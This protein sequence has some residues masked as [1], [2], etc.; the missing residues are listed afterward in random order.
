MCGD[1][2]AAGTAGTGGS[3][4]RSACC[5]S[6]FTRVRDGGHALL[7]LFLALREWAAG[8]GAGAEA[9]GSSRGRLEEE[10][11]G[12]RLLRHEVAQLHVKLQAL[13]AEMVG[14]LPAQGLGQHGE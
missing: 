13:A 7:L 14:S 9:G 1:D 3:D 6:E 5:C 4:H 10:D 8:S 2:E 11:E 12:R